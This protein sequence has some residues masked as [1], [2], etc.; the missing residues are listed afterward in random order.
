MRHIFLMLMFFCLAF[1]GVAVKA[2]QTLQVLVPPFE[3]ESQP[4]AVYFFNVLELAL[5]K[6]A[7][8]D[9]PFNIGVAQRF[10]SIE[11]LVADLKR[12]D[13]INVIWT[14]IDKER[15]KELLP[16]K[17]SLLKELNN[18]RLLLIRAEDQVIFDKVGGIEDLKKLTVGIGSQWP[19]RKILQRNGL[20]VISSTAYLPLF[21]MLAA[22]RFDY[23]PRG[24]YEIW[25][26]A[27]D[28]GH[29]GLTIEKS[30]MLYYEAP[31][32]FFVNK[33]NVALASRIERGLK[34]AIMDGSFDQMLQSVPAFKRGLEEQAR[35]KRKVIVLSSVGLD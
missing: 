18:Y 3:R 24:L 31:F 15:E 4:Q 12:G 11:R 5:Q 19:E 35:S 7:E 16:I 2:E 9:G 26:E 23:F 20:R 29:L 34:I 6:T 33:K 13:D 1:I 21:K 30:L 27:E 8:T 25:N 14:T 10:I 22:K 17:V 32:Y 28:N